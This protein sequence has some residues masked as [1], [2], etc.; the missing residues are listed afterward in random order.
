MKQFLL[1]TFV[2]L[3]L[4]GDSSAQKDSLQ[5]EIN[6]QVWKPFIQSFNN[7][8]DEGFK[9]VHSKD[10]IRVMQ[11]NNA[12]IGYDEYF[13]VVPDSLKSKWSNWKKNIELRFTQ[14]IAANGKAFDV[15]YYKTSSTNT[16]TGEIRSGYGKFYVLLRKESGTWKILMD[17]DANEKTNEAV[18]LTGSPME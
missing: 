18:F 17:A 16:I 1:S 2:L 13:K 6:E 4:Y 12:I 11:D 14:R 9:G 5:R 10:I 3:L 15:G 7:N 8:D